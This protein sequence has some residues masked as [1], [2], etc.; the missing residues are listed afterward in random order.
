MPI[1][2]FEVEAYKKKSHT[3]LVLEEGRSIY[4]LDITCCDCDGKGHTTK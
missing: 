3:M 2:E 4:D 1:A